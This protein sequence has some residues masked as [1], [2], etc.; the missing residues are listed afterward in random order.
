MCSMSKKNNPHT[1]V[2]CTMEVI[3]D[4]SGYRFSVFSDDQTPLS[5]Q[6]I[7]D[8]V[9]DAVLIEFGTDSLQDPD[10]ELPH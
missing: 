6:Q 3:E 8:A 9:S 2:H 4:G 1:F 5:A 10:A 7:M